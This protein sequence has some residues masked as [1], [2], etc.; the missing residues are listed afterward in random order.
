M[1]EQDQLP[2]LSIVTV[3]LNCANLLRTCMEY[4]A[5]QDYPRELIEHIIVDG[6][7]TDGTLEVARRF[8]ARILQHPEW[9]YHQEARH[10]IGATKARNDIVVYIDSDNF[11]TSSAWLREMVQ[12]LVEDSE[13]IATQTLRYGLRPGDPPPDSL[14]RTIGSQRSCSLLPE[15]A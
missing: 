5:R 3:T 10:G 12:P 4:V 8:G 9:G 1:I 11:M 13:I 14:L 6:G 7:S 15:Q 2:S